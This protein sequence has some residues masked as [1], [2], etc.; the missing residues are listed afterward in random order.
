MPAEFTEPRLL[1]VEGPADEMLFQFLIRHLR[2]SGIQIHNIGGVTNLEQELLSLTQTPGFRDEVKSL[3]IVRDADDDSE[4]AFDAVCVALEQCGL[5]APSEPLEAFGNYPSAIVLILP[6][7]ESSGALDDVCLASVADDPVMS[8]VED[9]ID[10][11]LDAVDAQPNNLSKSKL[12]AFLSS[13]REPGMLL[14]AAARANY[15]NFD[16][17]AFEPL[18]DFLR[19]M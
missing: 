1:V 2:L 14:G 10:C 6:H 9:Y 16:H 8:C 11:M 15:W 17:I 12:Q 13:R 4:G 18:K 3:G 19:M 5:S 7:G